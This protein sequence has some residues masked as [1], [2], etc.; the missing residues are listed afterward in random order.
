VTDKPNLPNMPIT[1]RYIYFAGTLPAGLTDHAGLVDHA[2][3]M[4]AIMRD[5]AEVIRHAHW[6]TRQVDDWQRR[7]TLRDS[8]RERE[9]PICVV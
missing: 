1:H 6:T 5:K 7:V 8:D 4:S 2:S 3:S 9:P